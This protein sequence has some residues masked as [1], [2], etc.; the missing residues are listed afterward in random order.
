MAITLDGDDLDVVGADAK[1]HGEKP[2]EPR[3]LAL[4]L[5]VPSP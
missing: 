5:A 1:L 2:D 3:W 4:S